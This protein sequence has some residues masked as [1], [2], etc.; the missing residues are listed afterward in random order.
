MMAEYKRNHT[1]PRALLEY[2]VDGTTSHRGVHVYDI[3]AQRSYI[4]S[5][6]G[7]KPFSFAIVND[8][9]V[10]TENGRRLVA[11]EKWFSALESSLVQFA[12]QLHAKRIPV[13]FDG[14]VGVDKTLKALLGL[15]CRSRYNLAMIQREL[16]RNQALHLAL[17]RNNG[18]SP[19]KATLENLIQV[20]SEQVSYVTPAT[21]AVYHPPKNK[22]WIISDRPFVPLGTVASGPRAVVLTPKVLVT[23]ERSD[24]LEL[25]CGYFDAD[26]HM[27]EIVNRNVALCARDWIVAESSRTLAT[28][29]SLVGTEEWRRKVATDHLSFLPIKFSRTGWAIT[30]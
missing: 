13:T 28:Y 22:S 26:D 30:R 27:V 8:L 7:A 10:P 23:Y 5:G 12:R 11:L 15:E 25:K 18:S 6:I 29:A 4:S 3:R 20:V 21:F 17:T 19:K 16:E 9:H 2:W 14:R 24:D 1:I